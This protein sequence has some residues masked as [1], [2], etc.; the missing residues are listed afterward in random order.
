MKKCGIGSGQIHRHVDVFHWDDL[1]CPVLVKQWPLLYHG[2]AVLCALGAC[3]CIV[4]HTH[5]PA[6]GDAAASH[7]VVVSIG[8]SLPGRN[9][10]QRRM[11]I[12]SC[13]VDLGDGQP[14][15]ASRRNGTAAPW[16]L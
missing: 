16:F 11:R 1:G 13:D 14:G 5:E 3:H 2:P 8:C 9:G 12:S 7:K 4:E 15:V 6:A 10:S